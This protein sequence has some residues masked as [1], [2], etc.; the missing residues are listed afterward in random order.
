MKKW[1]CASCG[2]TA[3]AHASTEIG[4]TQECIGA[5]CGGMMVIKGPPRP[6]GTNGKTNP[7]RLKRKKPVPGLCPI[8]LDHDCGDEAC[9]RARGL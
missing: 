2:R 9:L 5:G 4:S 3:L 7:P 1:S 6:K 8:C